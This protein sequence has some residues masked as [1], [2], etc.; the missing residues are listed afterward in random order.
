MSH[1]LRT[2]LVSQSTQRIADTVMTSASTFIPPPPPAA[3]L[4]TS[5][6]YSGRL[7]GARQGKVSTRPRVPLKGQSC[8]E[9]WS[10]MAEQLA[11]APSPQTQADVPLVENLPWA[12]NGLGEVGQWLKPQTLDQLD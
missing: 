10:G 1:G 9:S 2:C 12:D 6:I 5:G 11:R 8:A 7:V 4:G 3:P